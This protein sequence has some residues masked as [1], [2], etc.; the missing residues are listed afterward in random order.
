MG[1]AEA[2]VAKVYKAIDRCRAFGLK[3]RRLMVAPDVMGLLER[4]VTQLGLPLAKALPGLEVSEFF[5]LWLQMDTSLP[6]G[7]VL[8][9]VEPDE[10]S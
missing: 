4:R 10:R 5:G 8:V 6:A 9:G 1:S 3:P 2:A 7:G